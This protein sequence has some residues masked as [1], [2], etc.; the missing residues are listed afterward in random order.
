M[1]I[2]AKD[3][4]IMHNAIKLV[5]EELDSIMCEPNKVPHLIIYEYVAISITHIDDEIIVEEL[6]IQGNKSNLL[7]QE[8]EDLLNSEM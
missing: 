6:L 3:C 4:I 7:K 1:N 5:E 2:S 8:L